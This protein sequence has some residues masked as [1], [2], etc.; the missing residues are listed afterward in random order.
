[1]SLMTSLSVVSTFNGF[2]RTPERSSSCRVADPQ[3]PGPPHS[4][5]R[6]PGRARSASEARWPGLPGAVA[7]TRLFAAIGT[8]VESIRPALAT[9]A[10][11]SWS[12]ETNTSAPLPSTNSAERSDEPAKMNSTEVPAF[13][14]SNCLPIAV[15][16]LVIADDAYTVMD[17][18]GA[19]WDCELQPLAVTINRVAAAIV[20]FNRRR[21]G[22]DHS[23]SAATDETHTDMSC[24]GLASHLLPISLRLSHQPSVGGRLDDV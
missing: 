15:R 14:A 9:A 3:P 20:C 22:H 4:A 2:S 1:T 23:D 24:C 17:V 5:A 7:I 11:L 13:S 19:G 18:V 8:G 16:L 12:P 6:T 21:I 10:M